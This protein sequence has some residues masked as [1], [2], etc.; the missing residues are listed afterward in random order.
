MQPDNN[1][2]ASP[3]VPEPSGTAPV[4]TEPVIPPATPA[5]AP[6]ATES[7]AAPTPPTPAEAP[8]GPATPV[9][10]ASV[11]PD[12]AGPVAHGSKT[13]LILVIAAIILLIAGFL[14]LK[15]I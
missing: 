3:A 9:G 1:P 7:A 2:S 8:A 11:A 6:A 5:P 10:T 4:P 12:P 15:L 13:V 14:A